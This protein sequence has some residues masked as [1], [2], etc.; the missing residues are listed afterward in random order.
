M[1]KAGE[2]LQFSESKFYRIVYAD[3]VK[4]VAIGINKTP[5][6]IYETDKAI[7]FS[8][9]KEDYTEDFKIKKIESIEAQPVKIRP[10]VNIT[11]LA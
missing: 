9:K 10:L 11:T 3:N 1:F 6:G 8:N 7:V 5:T 4:A 2:I